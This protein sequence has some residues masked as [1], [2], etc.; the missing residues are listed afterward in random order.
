LPAQP[1][2]VS[3]GGILNLSSGALGGWPLTYQWYRNGAAIP[4]E[5][6]AIYYRVGVTDEDAGYY[7]VRVSNACGTTESDPIE[8]TVSAGTT[9]V[10]PPAVTLSSPSADGPLLSGPEI[11]VSGSASDDVEVAAVHVSLNDGAWM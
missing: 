6:S 3:A 9:D 5:T 8:V 10:Q 2:T 1:V 4:G 7:Q 11:T